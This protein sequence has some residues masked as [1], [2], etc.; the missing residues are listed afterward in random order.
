M[1]RFESLLWAARW[2]M[3]APVVALLVGAVYFAA[4][5]L[6]DIYLGLLSHGTEAVV[7]MIRAVDASLLAAVFVIF[8]LG[9]Y[10]L[11]I[12]PLEVKNAVFSRVLEVV[13]L[14]DLKA[15]L[16]KVVVMLLIVKFFEHVQLT[17]I[18]G[19]VEMAVFAGS[20]FMLAA[21]LW[22]IREREG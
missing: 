9:L 22:L 7:N 14:D 12:A 20:I 18:E 17:K 1:S 13:S 5:A 3:L 21:A 8:A 4:L 6:E 15:K 16:G 11:F 2:L 19:P 10:E